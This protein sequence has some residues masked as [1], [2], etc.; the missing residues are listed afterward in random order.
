MI[1]V[2][3]GG[4]LMGSRVRFKSHL[5]PRLPLIQIKRR[6]ARCNAAM[7]AGRCA[8]DGRHS[9]SIA[10]LQA[11]GTAF[12]RENAPRRPL[13]AGVATLE[14]P[15]REARLAV[16]KGPQSHWPQR[17]NRF[18]FAKRCHARAC[19]SPGF[20]CAG[21][22]EERPTRAQSSTRGQPGEMIEAA[23]NPVFSIDPVSRN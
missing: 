21:E 10:T 23:W 20:S 13:D 18:L 14:N 5:P 17:K 6:T 12:Q 3:L 16:H 2:F 1:R 15:S 22:L 7:L 11:L 19:A 4:L 8:R 9:G